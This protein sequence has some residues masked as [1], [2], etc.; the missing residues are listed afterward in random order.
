MTSWH[1]VETGGNGAKGVNWNRD[2]MICCWLQFRWASM[3]DRDA[4]VTSGCVHARSTG[5]VELPAESW[6]TE[7][8]S[9]QDGRDATL[10]NVMNTNKQNKQMQRHLRPDSSDLLNSSKAGEVMN[11]A[12]FYVLNM[13][14]M[15]DNCSRRRRN[16]SKRDND[17]AQ[18]A[19]HTFPSAQQEMY[20]WAWGWDTGIQGCVLTLFP[21]STKTLINSHGTDSTSIRDIL[22]ASSWIP[23]IS[24]V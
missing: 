22:S 16:V 18:S 20:L 24:G 9:L 6:K 12:E 8:R 21:A 23:E 2:N 5:H 3:S 14:E 7:W 19:F 11:Q 10:T 1:A 15:P 13:P 17:N 4:A